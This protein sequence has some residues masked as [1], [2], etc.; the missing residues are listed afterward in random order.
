MGAK[1]VRM[2]GFSGI[3]VFVFGLSLFQF[4]ALNDGR[5]LDPVISA[6]VVFMTVGGGMLIAV[7]AL[8]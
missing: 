1:W 3:G 4:V 6:G 2:L 8:R 5:T 7:R